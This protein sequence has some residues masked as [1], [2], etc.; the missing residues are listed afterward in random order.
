MPAIIAP[1]AQELISEILPS[2]HEA[3]NPYFD[4][5]FGASDR[6]RTELH[7]WMKRASSEIFVERVVILR[8]DDVVVGGFI[9]VNGKELEG[10]RRMDMTSLV[11]SGNRQYRE[12][13]SSRLNLVRDLFS[14]VNADEFYLS[15]LWVNPDYR[16]SGCS[17]TLMKS[18][19]ELG[20]KRGYRNFRLD[21][22]VENR[23]AV[24]L[25]GALGFKAIHES[26]APNTPLRYA[27]MAAEFETQF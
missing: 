16:G 1:A 21:V 9:A 19:I 4:F 6:A 24:H 23:A 3:G 5:I 25:Y 7:K 26:T 13:V 22:S 14:R 15:K 17:R 27:G 11:M 12:E 2:I 18:F 10:C 8:M 20:L